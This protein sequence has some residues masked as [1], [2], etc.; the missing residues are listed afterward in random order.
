MQDQI[1]TLDRLKRALD[2]DTFNRVRA[3]AQSGSID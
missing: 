3:L 1:G 2:P